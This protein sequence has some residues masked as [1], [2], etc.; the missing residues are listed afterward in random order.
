MEWLEL[1]SPQDVMVHKSS[2]TMSMSH[3]EMLIP[4]DGWKYKPTLDLNVIEDSV[5]GWNLNIHTE[6]FV[7]DAKE[8]EHQDVEGH[9]HA[10]IY[11]NGAKL[12]RVYCDW[13][14]IGSLPV[15]NNELKV[16]LYSNDHSGLTFEGNK[17]SSEITGLSK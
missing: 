11:V 2:K 16:S 7:F 8:A 9:G 14:H 5:S 1:W 10:H 15:G 17:I 3:A 13:Y 4:V 12:S 6:N